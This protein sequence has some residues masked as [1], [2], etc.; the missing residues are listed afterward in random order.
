MNQIA[1]PPVAEAWQQL[2]AL[3]D[4]DETRRLADV[5][6]RALMSE[7]TEIAAAERR[8][9]KIGEE[10]GEA[11]GKVLG[12]KIGEARA[13][14]RHAQAKQEALKALLAEGMSEARAKAILG[15]P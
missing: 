2:R 7:L 15:L 10:V 4:D 1:W 8:G 13:E 3:S 11:R 5:R 14:A 12:E 9:K 6:E